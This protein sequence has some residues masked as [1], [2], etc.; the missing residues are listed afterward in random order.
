MTS[1]NHAAQNDTGFVVTVIGPQVI[2]TLK[3]KYQ[4]PKRKIINKLVI[5]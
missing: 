2:K 1:Q 5:K 3:V 4:S